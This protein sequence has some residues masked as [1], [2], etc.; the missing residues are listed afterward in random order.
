MWLKTTMSGLKTSL[1]KLKI[2]KRE[3]P[4]LKDAIFNE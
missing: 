2:R 1:K 3:N 4:D